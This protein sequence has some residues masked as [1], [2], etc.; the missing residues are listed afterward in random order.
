MRV[1]V[2]RY[3]D[4][5]WSSTHD[6]PQ[7]LD[8]CS[9]VTVTSDKAFPCA[10]AAASW[11]VIEVLSP[12]GVYYPMPIHRCGRHAPGKDEVLRDVTRDEAAAAVVMGS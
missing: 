11:H 1:R 9:L 5:I 8:V 4:G 10:G 3:E 6:D 7:D 12:H 2:G